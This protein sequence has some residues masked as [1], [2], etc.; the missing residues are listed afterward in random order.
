MPSSLQHIAQISRHP[1]FIGDLEQHFASALAKRATADR[2]VILF[3][4][5]AKHGQWA[6]NLLLNLD[7]LNIGGRALAIGSSAEACA[8]ILF[9]APSGS[10]TCGNSTYMR[11]ASGNRTLIDALDTWHIREWHVYHL[12]WQRWHYLSWAVRLGYNA[13]S[14]DMDISLRANPYTLFHGALRH[15]QLLV[16]LDSEAGGHERPGAFPM[17]NVGLV[18]CQRCRPDGPAHRVLTEVGRRVHQYLFGPLL[19]KTKGKNT[20]MAERVL[21]EQDLFKDALEGVAFGLPPD[22]SRH[23]LENA[24]PPLGGFPRD[25]TARMRTW[26]IEALSLAGPNLPQQPTPWLQLQ[27]LSGGSGTI[28]AAES[29]AG[30]PLWIFSPWNV[31]PHG[32]A[33]AGQWARRPSPV[34]IGHLVGCTSKHLIMRQLGWWHY[35]VSAYDALIATQR[36]AVITRPAQT[37]AATTASS[38]PPWRA[39]AEDTRV[40]VLRAHA[41][42]ISVPTDVH[43]MW[44]AVRRFSML[45]LAVGRRAVIPLVPCDLTPCAP[46]VPNPLR[47]SLYTVTIGDAGACDDST[48]AFATNET[49]ARELTPRPHESPI[50]W[51]PSPDTSAWWWQPG[52][53]AASRVSMGCCQPI[54]HFAS[55][56][57]PAGARRP[58]GSEPLL[59]TADLGRFL[60]E[61][62]PLAASSADSVISTITLA[63]SWSDDSL[64][65]LRERSQAKV[66]GLNA[67]RRVAERLPSVD[68]L[69]THAGAGN[70][71]EEAIGAHAARCFNALGKG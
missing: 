29:A 48:T 63:E 61:V 51:N 24:N 16:G 8:A 42:H 46:R 14:L 28:A 66:L 6:H 23:A 52:R 64:D 18:Y 31:P 39:F 37:S 2:E 59:A 21:W 30:L 32:S 17:I 15:R 11:R 71:A 62:R 54:P 4:L 34:M 12:W 58:L 40:L 7:E 53:K 22:V 68:W 49:S 56:I 57:D 19:W 45:A 38:S 26:R 33:C 47:S 36:R 3:V 67:G 27:P 5:D 55:C 70:A 20:I 60:E 69:V 1:D 10:V 35:Q 9:R 65:E 50:G 25:P 43:G 44:D 41:L 13:M